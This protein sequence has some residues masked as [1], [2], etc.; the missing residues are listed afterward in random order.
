MEASRDLGFHIAAGR[1]ILE[2][3]GW[4]QVDSFTWTLAGRPYVDMNG[5][6]QVVLALAYG[7]AGMLGVGLLRVALTVATFGLLWHSIRGRGVESP[8]L[9]GIGFAIALLTWEV[10]LFTR[11]ELISGLC[12]A[13][14]LHLLRR[15]ADTGDRRFLFATVP[16][17]LV[18]VYSHSLSLFGVAVLGLYAVT[19]GRD[20]AP[21]IALAAAAAVMFLNPY[22][23]RGVEWQLSL[24]ARIAAGNPFADTQLELVSPFSADAARFPALVFFRLM[25]VV[26]AVVLV[27]GARRISRFEG[28]V[29]ALFGTLAAVHMRIVA[30][31][32]IAALPVVLEAASAIV[33]RAL[34]K[35]AVS[36]A[37]L[38]GIVFMIQQTISGGVYAFD[39]YPFRFGSGESPAVFPIGTAATLAQFKG[40]LFNAVEHGGYL[41]LHRP[42]LKTFI[43]GRLEVMDEDF[44]LPYL[45]A[46][47]GGDGWDALENRWHPA[48]ALVPANDR[49]LVTHLLDEPGW[50]LVDVDTVAFLFARDTPDQLKAIE[51]NQ[52]RLARL[53][54]PA[55]PGAD[56]IA[57]PPRPS[58]LAALFGSNDVPFESFGRGANFLQL[59]MFEAARRDLRQ[60]LLASARAEPA[61]IKAYVIATA[62]LGRLDES[63]AW[64]RR[65]VDL[66]P[67]DEEARTLLA[68]L[69]SHGS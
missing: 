54:A 11:P 9:L 29:V 4:P 66:S 17:Q 38:L 48:V 2:H 21:W 1:W 14:Q 25:L 31:F 63:R 56:A 45:R 42:D 64:C 24:G 62:Q 20:V 60:A 69:Q 51:A 58:R 23:I 27:A 36:A 19:R 28:A 32:A 26:T 37:A 65:L 68:S 49:D 59:G 57:P 67:Q 44:F 10:R 47:E 55:T 30:M 13:G 12:L 33:G 46:L 15:H 35:K 16:L 53:N 18:W 41:E 61:L 43:D 6:F 8:V 52:E 7:A 39:R 40:P 5:L 3:G 34:E 50:T 22:G